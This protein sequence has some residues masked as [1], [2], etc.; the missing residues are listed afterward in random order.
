VTEKIASNV[1]VDNRNKSI[2]VQYTDGSRGFF[3]FDTFD[4]SSMRA[5]EIVR[6][7]RLFCRDVTE[8]AK[9]DEKTFLGCLEGANVILGSH[10]VITPEVAREAQKE[11]LEQIKEKKETLE[12]YKQY[13]L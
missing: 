8:A 3:G 4:I 1:Y 10:K 12:A 6:K 11:L 9:G 5:E 7:T 2:E 13:R